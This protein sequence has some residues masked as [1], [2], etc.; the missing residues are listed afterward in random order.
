MGCSAA[1]LRRWWGSR[2]PAWKTELRADLLARSTLEPS[3]H[4]LRK[5]SRLTDRKDRAK[6][7][8]HG[9]GRLH[10]RHDDVPN[11]IQREAAGGQLATLSAN[12][13]SLD[14]VGRSTDGPLAA[15]MG[16]SMIGAGLLTSVE[17]SPKPPLSPY[18]GHS[19]TSLQP[20]LATGVAAA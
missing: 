2:L 10:T 15:E 16:G 13:R 3:Q 9:P 7:L 6:P 17:F 11:A 1:S 12:D 20:T 8:F 18:R 19:G 4:P 14:L 5:A